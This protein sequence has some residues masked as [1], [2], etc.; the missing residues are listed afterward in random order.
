M[1]IEEATITQLNDYLVAQLAPICDADPSVL[2]DYVMA[3]LRHDQ[4]ID[5]LKTLCISQLEDFL[6]ES[7]GPFVNSLF[8]TVLS[9]GYAREDGTLAESSVSGLNE[10][11]AVEQAEAPATSQKFHEEEVSDDEDGDRNFKHTRRGGDTQDLGVAD[12]R[13]SRDDAASR[14]RVRSDDPVQGQDSGNSAYPRQDGPQNEDLTASHKRLKS[15][16]ANPDDRNKGNRGFNGP[17]AA[18]QAGPGRRDFDRDGRHMGPQRFPPQMIP[19]PQGLP[20]IPEK[21][22]CLRGDACPYDHGVD[23]IVVDDL[24]MVGGRPPFEMMGPNP[25]MPIP[26]M[27]GPFHP[28]GGR[29]GVPNMRPQFDAEPYEPG[30]SMPIG[31]SEAYDPER[32]SFA[33]AGR[34]PGSE[35][36]VG[37]AEGAGN[38]QLGGGAPFQAGGPGGPENFQSGLRG[39]FARRGGRGGAN[40]NSGFGGHHQQ[41]NMGQRT[42]GGNPKGRAS[43]DTLVVQNVP[44]E[45]LTID[46]ISEFFKK[47]G[48][49]T[50]IK[51]HVPTSKA[52][53]Q[54]S[55]PAEAQAAYRSPDPIFDNRF[56]KVFFANPDNMGGKAETSPLPTAPVA[57]TRRSVIT[58]DPQAAAAEAQKAAAAAAAAAEEKKEKT[59]Q[60]LEMQQNLIAKQIE[61]QKKIMEKLQSKTLLP[62]EKKALMSQFEI[63]SKSMKDVMHSASTRVAT[64]QTQQASKPA[65]RAALMEEKERERL[66]RELDAISQVQSPAPGAVPAEETSKSATLLAQLEALKAQAAARGIDPNA[67]LAAGSTRGGSSHPYSG[68][69]RGSW[70]GGRGSGGRFTLD[71]RTKKL[72]V[73]NVGSSGHFAL[74]AH[75]EKFGSI[76]NLT[77]TDDDSSAIVEYGS[78][79]DAERAMSEPLKLED[80]DTAELSWFTGTLPSDQS[81]A[82]LDKLSNGSAA[83]LVDPSSVE[84]TAPGNTTT[85]AQW[86]DEEE[87]EDH[88]ADT[89]WKRR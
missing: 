30:M 50:N 70:A 75:F 28:Y 10:D 43:N 38:G 12:G 55:T 42:F 78:R 37:A 61:E 89:S 21:G 36:G 82:S 25:M 57:S 87:E 60:M 26:G 52:V 31:P 40:F 51:L 5:G 65:S 79:R 7:T 2:A 27:G 71:N 3:L 44:A 24:P 4:P 47:F 41:G 18:F 8:D 45:H 39:G 56:V 54:F 6:K 9:E 17:N 48:T 81:S 74:R 22:Y 63:L 80:F 73:K 49:I 53:L 35:N 32:A 16:E 85:T 20:L 23:R 88:D 84:T 59:K 14:K 19:P 62:Q 66:D 83:A 46:K 64:I 13:T 67:V 29:P 15:G 76:N 34:R 1:H 33:A 58:I 69:G 72:L 86:E 77:S 11:P 68:R